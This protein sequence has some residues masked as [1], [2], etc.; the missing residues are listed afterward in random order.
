MRVLFVCTGNIC[1]SP[2]AEGVLRARLD[3]LGLD[4]AIAVDS[5]GT[6]GYH[7]GD[8]P[9]SRAIGVCRDRGIDIAGLRARPWASG[10]AARFDLVVGMEDHHRRWVEKRQPAGSKIRVV[11]LLDFAP[12]QPWRDV[13]DPYYG[14]VQDFH[15]MLDLI[16]QGVDGLLAHLEPANPS[17][18]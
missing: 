1:R 14:G 6:H 16:E 3:S 13:P 12:D 2:S 5:C 7:T 10:D 9:D 4:H 11:R 18:G 8:P 17:R 15:E